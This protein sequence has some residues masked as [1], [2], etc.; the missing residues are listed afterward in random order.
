MCCTLKLLTQVVE[1]VESGEDFT[2][3]LAGIPPD[4]DEEEEKPKP[5]KAPAASSKK[6]SAAA[7]KKKAASEKP[8]VCATLAPDL[9]N[10][11]TYCSSCSGGWGR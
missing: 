10:Q 2:K 9:V 6:A 4:S 7:T 8:K 11:I 3:D 5:K 1:D